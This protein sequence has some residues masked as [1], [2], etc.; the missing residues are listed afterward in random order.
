MGIADIASAWCEWVYVATLRVDCRDSKHGICVCAE[1]RDRDDIKRHCDCERSA[2]DGRMECLSSVKASREGAFGVILNSSLVCQCLGFKEVGL[3][4][5]CSF[6]PASNLLFTAP[7]LNL[8][9]GVLQIRNVRVREAEGKRECWVDKHNE[10]RTVKR[11][12]VEADMTS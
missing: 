4:K 9:G 12:E 1:E 2:I 10:R 5:Y 11:P 6:Y 3:C 7:L 8:R